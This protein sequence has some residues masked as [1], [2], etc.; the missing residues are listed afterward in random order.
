MD[1]LL[2]RAM[3]GVDPD[4]PGAAL[5]IFSNLMGL[6]PWWNLIAWQVFFVVV[7]ALLGWW[8]GRTMAGI[9]GALVLGPFGWVVPFLPKRAPPAPP[10]GA[11][12]QPP[13]LPGSKKR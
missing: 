2:A 6:V 3:Q 1:E 13:P 10:A 9:V 8:R 4:D 12:P 5:R 11:G 7:G